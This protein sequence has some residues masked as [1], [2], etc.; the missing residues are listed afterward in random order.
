VLGQTLRAVCDFPVLTDEGP[1]V[2]KRR[3]QRNADYDSRAHTLRESEI[4]LKQ[5]A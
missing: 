1:S 5:I 3:S 2:I 4:V